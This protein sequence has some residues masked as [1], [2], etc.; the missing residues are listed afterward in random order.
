MMKKNI[1]IGLPY[2]S[3]DLL[4][5]KNSKKAI[6]TKGDEDQEIFNA[7]FMLEI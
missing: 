3:V 1:S 6:M 5:W 4:H 7:A 2:Y